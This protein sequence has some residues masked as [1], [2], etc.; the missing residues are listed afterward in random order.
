MSYLGRGKYAWPQLGTV[1]TEHILVR[2][3]TNHRHNMGACVLCHGNLIH[4][5]ASW[6]HSRIHSYCQPLCCRDPQMGTALL[7]T[8]SANAIFAYGV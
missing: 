4:S 6:G 2:A 5:Q 7:E 1:V 8:M 3:V